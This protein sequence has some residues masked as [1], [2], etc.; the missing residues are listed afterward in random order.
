MNRLE[1]WTALGGSAWNS[2][3]SYRQFLVADFKHVHRVSQSRSE[4]DW[5]Q[6]RP[7]ECCWSLPPEGLT[8]LIIL[9][10]PAIWATQSWVTPM[11][12]EAFPSHLFRDSE[13]GATLTM[14]WFG[15]W[16]GWFEANESNPNL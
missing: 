14:Q 1:I 2:G 12:N 9:D 8:L 6:P 3:Y 5:N 15:I 16:S 10:T 4:A 7:P 13:T 11:V